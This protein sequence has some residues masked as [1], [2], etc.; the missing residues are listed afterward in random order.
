M[1][2]FE[3]IGESTALV[4][5]RMRGHDFLGLNCP[6]VASVS[7]MCLVRLFGC[8][9]SMKMKRVGRLV[10]DYTGVEAPA[11]RCGLTNYETCA[12]H[13][14]RPLEIPEGGFPFWVNGL[15]TEKGDL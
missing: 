5:G 15:F 4:L 8:L 9:G 12:A 2:R 14:L 11:D 13:F 7:S 3:T 6:R 10:L 1:L